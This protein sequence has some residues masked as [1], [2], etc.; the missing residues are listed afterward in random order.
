M[1]NVYFADT[2]KGFAIA[3]AILPVVLP[4]PP[5]NNGNDNRPN[6]I[7]TTVVTAVPVAA[8]PLQNFFTLFLKLGF[9]ST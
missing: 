6:G 2:I 9:F 7:L 5:K 1:L 8:I 4:L 3:Y